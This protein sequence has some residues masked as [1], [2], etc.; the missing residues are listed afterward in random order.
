MIIRNRAK[1]NREAVYQRSLDRQSNFS[2]FYNYRYIIPGTHCVQLLEG[3]NAEVKCRQSSSF[4]HP[5]YVQPIVINDTHQ[6]VI[7][8]ILAAYNSSC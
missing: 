7:L 8:K 3:H 4:E 2:G 1:H 5:A 6:L